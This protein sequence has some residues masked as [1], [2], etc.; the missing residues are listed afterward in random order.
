MKRKLPLVIA[1]WR[2]AS[3]TAGWTSLDEAKAAPVEVTT[4]GWLLSQDEL[5]VSLFSSITKDQALGELTTI[6]A[7]WVISI[8]KL[9]G[10][11]MVVDD[12]GRG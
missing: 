8:K 12:G 6:P 5:S 11:R 2:D 4:V 1:I 3:T 9:R 7:P 10:N